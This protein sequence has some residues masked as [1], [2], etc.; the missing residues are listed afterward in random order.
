[1]D[2]DAE[3]WGT[4]EDNEM[5]AELASMSAAQIRR[6][7]SLLGTEVRV[8]QEEASRLEIDRS[9]LHEKITENTEKIKYN[10]QLPYL[11]GNIVEVCSLLSSVNKR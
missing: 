6:R 8:L 1:M 5:E 9:T 7:T 2:T 11:V 4:G 3:I 10:K